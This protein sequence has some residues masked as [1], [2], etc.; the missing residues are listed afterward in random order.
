MHVAP[1]NLAKYKRIFLHPLSLLTISPSSSSGLKYNLL[2]PPSSA[3]VSTSCISLSLQPSCP[4]SPLRLHASVIENG[5]ILWQ[6]LILSMHPRFTRERPCVWKWD[7][8]NWN[9]TL[10]DQGWEILNLHN[11]TKHLGDKHTGCFL[12]LSLSLS[13][14]P[15]V[16]TGT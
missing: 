3:F 14:L 12:S 2:L 5:G 8:C 15:S 10:R 6:P 9:V 16:T 7:P 4:R 11:Q 13:L 1:F